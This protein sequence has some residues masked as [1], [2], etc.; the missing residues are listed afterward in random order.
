MLKFH[1]SALISTICLMGI[2][3]GA[4]TGLSQTVQPVVRLTTKPTLSKILPFEAEAASRQ[5]PVQLILEAVDESDKPIENARIH[6]QILAPPQNPWV[7]TDFPK[8]EGTKLLDI[9]AVAPK[10]ELNV[11]QMLPI[12]GTYQL[13]VAVTPNAT[14][15]F[16]PIQKTLTLSVSENWVKYRNFGFLVAILFAVGLVGGWIIGGKQSI[17]AGEIAPQRVR[18]LLS[19]AVAIAIAALLIVNI[20]AELAESGVS[21]S[22]T[23]QGKPQAGSRAVVQ[24]QGLELRLLGD[25]NTTVGKIA[26]LQAEAIDT[27]THQPATDVILNVKTTQLEHE[28]VVFAYQGIPDATGKLTWQ[29]QF[30]DGAPHKVEVEVAPHSNAIRKFHPFRVKREIEVEGVAPPLSARL[31]TLALFASIIAIGLVIGL[32]QKYRWGLRRMDTDRKL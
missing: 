31:T 17:P 10:G 15:T 11:Q 13:R 6:L 16:I 9:K 27:Q 8:V 22:H 14:H 4:R 21:T 20:S 26:N 5:L 24:S 7:T 23:V 32:R 19:G 3:F 29:Q 18:L 2:V 30:F 28:W 1:S 25:T 12:R